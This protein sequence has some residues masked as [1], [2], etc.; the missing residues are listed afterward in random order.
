[1]SAQNE[2]VVQILLEANADPNNSRDG[3]GTA[4]QIAAFRGN[5][6]IIKHL[7]E[8]STDVDLH[9]GGDFDGVR[10]SEVNLVQAIG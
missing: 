8:A 6:L 5:E 1:M 9:C 4:L 10:S 7:L 3:W 2:K